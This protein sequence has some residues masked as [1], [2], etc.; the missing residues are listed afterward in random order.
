MPQKVKISM[1]RSVEINKNSGKNQS[2]SQNHSAYWNKQRLK[3]KEEKHKKKYHAI[4][5]S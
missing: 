1:H 4:D 5:H 2:K 3:N